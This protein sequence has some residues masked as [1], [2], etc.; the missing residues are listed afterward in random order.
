LVTFA[1][2]LPS[3]LK[4]KNGIKKYLLKKSMEGIL[5][6][7]VLNGSKKGFGV[8][9]KNWIKSPIKDFMLGVYNDSKLTKANLINFNELSQRVNDHCIGNKDWGISL[10]KMLN[11]C[12]WVEMYDIELDD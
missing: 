10:W 3:E 7:E 11:F 5:P 9:Y 4:V 8:P 1:L 6:N 2:S 12:L